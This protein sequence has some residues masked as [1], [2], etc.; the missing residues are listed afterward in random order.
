MKE[1]ENIAPDMVNHPKHYTVGGFEAI[2]VIEAKLTQ[3]QFKG[4]LLGTILKYQMR[5]NY[6]G[7]P[8]QDAKKA[9][10]FLDRLVK[11]LEAIEQQEKHDT[12]CEQRNLPE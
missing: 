10:W 9:Q 3:E 4:Y 8:L 12:D 11:K 1:A 6:K 7:K 5:H 2:D